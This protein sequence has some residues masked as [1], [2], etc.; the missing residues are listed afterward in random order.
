MREHRIS[1]VVAITDPE[2]KPLQGKG[3]VRGRQVQVTMEEK[4][5]GDLVSVPNP[6]LPLTWLP[7]QVDLPGVFQLREPIHLLLPFGLGLCHQ[8]CHRLLTLAV[9]I[10]PTATSSC[11]NIPLVAQRKLPGTG[12]RNPASR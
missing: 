11:H 5:A 1:A 8:C 7:I 10:S 6:T 9:P 3:L 12:L 4:K 2:R